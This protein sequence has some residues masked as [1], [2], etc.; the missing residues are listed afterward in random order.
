MERGLHLLVSLG[1][2]PSV[3]PPETIDFRCSEAGLQRR[4]AY[5]HD[6]AGDVSPDD[7]VLI[8]VQWEFDREAR[9]CECRAGDRSVFGRKR[10]APVQFGP[11]VIERTD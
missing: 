1:V 9:Q 5:A 8:K 7:V 4:V 11:H 2:R 6:A 3:T 10:H